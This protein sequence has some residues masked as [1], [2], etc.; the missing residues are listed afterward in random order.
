VEGVPEPLADRLMG[1]ERVVEDGLRAVRRLDDDIR[2]GECALDVA[3]L[4][5]PRLAGDQSAPYCFVGVEHDLELL[6]LHL[7]RRQ[8]GP[9]LPERVGRNRGDRRPREPR[10]LDE[11]VRLARAEH[12]ANAGEGERRREVDPPHARVGVRRAEDRRL[13]HPR[14]PD[15]R[16]EARLAAHPLRCVLSRSR[17]PH[18]RERA[19]G[20]LL[21]RILLDGDPD[22]LEAALDLFL[23]ADQPCHVRI[24][25]SIF[26][27]VPQRQMLPA[28][29]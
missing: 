23:G 20:P 22:L 15:V 6:P 9:R 16:R 10:L 27:Y 17:S 8:G 14:Q 18:D 1:L 28:I 24:A 11:P 21:E 4:L 3:A 12:R 7:D 19:C 25:S 13:E 5:T 29:A 2:L 26:G